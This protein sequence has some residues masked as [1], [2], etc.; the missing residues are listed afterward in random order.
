MTITLP[1]DP[2][3]PQL[4]DHVA[5]VLKALGY[6]VESRLIL[7]DNRKDILELDHI[8]SPAMGTSTSRVLFEVKRTAIKFPNLFKLY[9]QR[10]FLDID[11]ACLVGLDVPNAEHLP[12]YKA[13]GEQLG[14]RICPYTTD[15]SNYTALAPQLSALSK[16]ELG[17]VVSVG[18]FQEIAKRLA[19][20]AF[21]KERKAR[22]SS[23]ELSNVR[24]YSFSLHAAFFLPKPLERAEALYSAYLN[25]PKMSGAALAEVR[26]GSQTEE[27]QWNKVNDTNALPWAQAIM[28]LEW[29]ARLQIVKNALDDYLIRG[30]APPPHTTLQVG[31]LSLSVPLHALPSSFHAGLSKL[32][33]HKTPRAV[34]Y[35]FQ[36]FVEVFG[37]FLFFKDDRELALLS[38]MTGISSADIVPSLKLLDDFFGTQGSQFFT[39][40]DELLYLKMV[41]GTT[42]GTGAFLRHFLWADDYESEYPTSGWLLKRWH[43]SAYHLLSEELGSPAL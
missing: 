29:T 34:P 6:F 1:K 21:L 19:W 2:S 28:R 5:A 4:E 8:A 11:E 23:V 16:E 37:G 9:G 33:K 30:K 13:R 12:V 31:A 35:L 10:I 26:T 3:G 25:T 39:Q 22:P 20:A 41:P 18:W 42:K 7:Q 17:V 38:K 36:V 43:D 40:K 14:V 24:E 15:G 32:A 27:A